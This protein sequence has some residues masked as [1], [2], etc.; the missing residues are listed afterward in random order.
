MSQITRPAAGRHSVHRRTA[1]AGLVAAA[2]VGS[3][4][5]VPADAGR[6]GRTRATAS[7]SATEVVRDTAVSVSGTVE[8]RVT[9]SRTVRL[10][11]RTASGWRTQGKA[12]TTRQG[13]YS[14]EVPTWWTRSARLR[15][16][17]ART[18][19]ARADASTAQRV[20]VTEPYAPAGD[21]ASWAHIYRYP[22]RLDPCGTVTYRVNAA[23]GLPDPAT[24]EALAHAAVTRI[25]QATGMEF[26]YLGPTDA[27]FQGGGA[28]IPKDTDV[29][30]SWATDA[31]TRLDI[32]P[33]Y[34]GR[35]GASKA[36]WGRDARGRRMVLARNAG[37]VLDSQEQYMTASG[38][39]HVLMHELGHALGLGHVADPAQVMHPASYDVPDYQWGAG[40][41][42]GFEKVGVLAGCVRPEGRRGRFSAPGGLMLPAQP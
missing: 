20:T 34:A 24:A 22:V 10:Q 13:E 28:S 1:A 12:R 33:G 26:R 32:G 18:G 37:A 17:A 11:L 25:S 14:F 3:M 42:T 23:A 9:G 35:G 8:D 7:W 21:P 39:L 29:L 38:T 40:D 15:V 16:L 2:L 31:Q 41:L 36:V 27:V 5:A 4:H 6:P 30:V 19:R